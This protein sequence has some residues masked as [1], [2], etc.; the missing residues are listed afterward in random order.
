MA[1][2]SSSPKKSRSKSGVSRAEQKR[3]T[4]ERFLSAARECFAN[5]DVRDV[6]ML[7]ISSHAGT[8][9]GAIYVHFENRE[10][11]IDALVAEFRADLIQAMVGALT[12]TEERSVAS[13]IERLAETFLSKLAQLSPYVS[14]FAS[15]SAR[16]MSSD[17]L[18][19]GVAAPIVQMLNAT[20]GTLR[21]SVTF[22]GD[23]PVLASTIASIWRGVALAAVS[24]P[25]SDV[26][27]IAKTL[28]KLT[29]A[30]LETA[31]PAIH[32]VDARLLTRG[33][34]QFLRADVRVSGSEST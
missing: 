23:L 12:S 11:L 16:T 32:S 26:P 28:S 24:R 19:A 7:D 21:A 18:R 2:P 25:M 15:Y 14:M 10:A 27:E 22:D 33:M 13:A 6:H 9:V 17:A 1:N 34:A 20:L 4:Y 31:A 29:L 3:A 8:S 30:V 5:R